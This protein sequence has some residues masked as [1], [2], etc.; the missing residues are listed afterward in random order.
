M[1]NP[2]V[3]LAQLP[4]A[5]DV[6]REHVPVVRASDYL[7][8][9]EVGVH[10]LGDGVV[11]APTGGLSVVK[12]LPLPLVFALAQPNAPCPSVQASH[13]DPVVPRSGYL[14]AGDG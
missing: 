3:V 7:G 9:H 1:G 6:P 5:V 13:L 10:G 2:P 11:H 12:A 8:A 4:D 14:R